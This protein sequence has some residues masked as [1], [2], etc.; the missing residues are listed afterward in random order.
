MSHSGWQDISGIFYSGILSGILSGI[1]TYCTY[2]F[3]GGISI[4]IPSHTPTTTPASS[5]ISWSSLGT[6]SL[7]ASGRP[8]LDRGG[9]SDRLLFPARCSA[10][11]SAIQPICPD[12]TMSFLIQPVRSHSLSR[13]RVDTDSSSQHRARYSYFSFN[14]PSCLVRYLDICN[15]C[16]NHTCKLLLP[17]SIIYAASLVLSSIDSIW[18]QKRQLRETQILQQNLRNNLLEAPNSLLCFC[19]RLSQ[20]TYR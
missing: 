10:H 17:V 4:T 13:Y 19:S 7:L 6:S 12:T 16:Y 3:I 11:D 14:E 15:S 8:P 9:R 20:L 1:R 2:S 5:I 18:L